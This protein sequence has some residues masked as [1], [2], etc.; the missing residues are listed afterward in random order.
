[1]YI[2]QTNALTKAS[3]FSSIS[4][5]YTSSS[6]HICRRESSPGLQIHTHFQKMLRH[7]LSVVSFFLDTMLKRFD[8]YIFG[9]FITLLRTEC[10][11]IFRCIDVVGQTFILHEPMR[12]RRSHLMQQQHNFHSVNIY[13]FPKLGNVLRSANH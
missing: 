11:Y 3:T 4:I 1:M 13:L 5:N 10:E 12:E 2:F 8:V 9:I 7:N 6:F